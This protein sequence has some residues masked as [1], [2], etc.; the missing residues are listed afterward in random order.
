M[1]PHFVK[2][3]TSNGETRWINLAAAARIT[4]THEANPGDRLLVVVFDSN[5]HVA[6]HGKDVVNNEAIDAVLN[7]VEGSTLGEYA[8]GV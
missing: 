6:I 5:D 2:F 4:L 7:F 1:K 3:A 8:R